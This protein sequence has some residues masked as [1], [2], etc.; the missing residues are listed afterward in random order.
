MLTITEMIPF[1]DAVWLGELDGVDFEKLL[2]LADEMKQDQP[3]GVSVSNR[4]GWQSNSF[5]D[6]TVDKYKNASEFQN[7]ITVLTG[8]I[9]EGV[10]HS[11]KPSEFFEIEPG[12]A[13]FNFNLKN[14]Y[15]ILHN[16]PGSVFSSVVYLT[17]DNSP[18]VLTDVGS[19]RNTSAAVTKTANIFQTQ[20]K[21]TPKKGDY[22][23][24]P[25]W[26]LHYVEQNDKDNL[27]VSLAINFKIHTEN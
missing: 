6:H 14:D 1:K 2:S 21:Y 12:N 7:L 3:V 20:F 23:I 11:Y 18:L 19:S 16:H 26:F 4:G 5:W 13:W 25:S 27:R 9:Q 22:I 24:F 17:D 8:L 10:N 15:N